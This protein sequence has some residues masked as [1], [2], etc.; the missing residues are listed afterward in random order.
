MR[1]HPRN[2]HAFCTFEDGE[3]IGEFWSSRRSFRQFQ[4]HE[5]CVEPFPMSSQCLSL[6]PSAIQLGSVGRSMACAA[7]MLE[8]S[9]LLIDHGAPPEPSCGA[10]ALHAFRSR[11]TASCRRAPP[12][13]GASSSSR[14]GRTPRWQ[15]G[16]LAARRASQ[17]RLVA[18]ERGPQFEPKDRFG[19]GRP[20]RSLHRHPLRIHAPSRGYLGK[21]PP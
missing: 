21:H 10:A 18:A 17:R 19:P 5:Y 7:V 16:R 8:A 13:G 12:Y 15:R 11:C 4:L 6:F 1:P 14:R 3:W 9:A 20:P 2:A